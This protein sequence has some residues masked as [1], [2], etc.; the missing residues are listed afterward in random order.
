[1]SNKHVPVFTFDLVQPLDNIVL[2]LQGDGKGDD[3][4]NEEDG[5]CPDSPK[6]AYVGY[7]NGEEDEDRI[8]RWR[9]LQWY[10]APIVQEKEKEKEKTEWKNMGVGELRL[11][12]HKV[13]G[14]SRLV[15]RD[16]YLK[17]VHFNRMIHPYDKWRGPLDG[18][19]IDQ[20]AEFQSSQTENGCMTTSHFL[21]DSNDANNSKEHIAWVF[22][23]KPETTE[24][25]SLWKKHR[26]I[27]KQIIVRRNSTNTA[28]NP[29]AP[30]N[31]TTAAAT[32]AATP[33]APINKATTAATTAAT[34]T[35][36]INKAAAATAATPTALINKVN[37]A[38]ATTA[39]AAVPV[40][41]T[42]PITLTTGIATTAAATVLVG[43]TNPITLTTGA[44]SVAAIKQG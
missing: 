30:T 44:A 20:V 3:D 27:N 18:L 29:T 38:S 32:T 26:E 11:L 13:S 33:T 42:Y 15:F 23:H 6:P 22:Q 37:T 34:P 36:P 16:K 1:M 9:N 24:F 10:R 35:A 41:S 7:V 31:A 25:E 14:M 43:S 4:G 39:D 40:G 17:R 19:I 12:Q 2:P 8:G 5:S 21:K 28:A